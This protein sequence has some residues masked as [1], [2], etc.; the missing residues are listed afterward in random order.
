[1]I[2][3][4]NKYH[5]VGQWLAGHDDIAYAELWMSWPFQKE[6]WSGCLTQSSTIYSN[7]ASSHGRNRESDKA[8]AL[9]HIS[10]CPIPVWYCKDQLGCKC[11]LVNKMVLLHGQRKVGTV[12]L[13]QDLRKS[14]PITFYQKPH[15]K[16]AV[17][18]RRDIAIDQFGVPI[19]RMVTTNI[20][21]LIN[22]LLSARK[23]FLWFF[24]WETGRQQMIDTE[25]L[26]TD[27][28]NFARSL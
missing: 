18:V 6:I 14:I 22:R 17:Q 21:Q 23:L 5:Q 9:W 2:T 1:M 8:N 13:D 16:G 10:Q 27:T 3:W 7:I 25:G 11:W 19:L 28:E 15:R 20:Y 4:W 12:N 24:S 26:D